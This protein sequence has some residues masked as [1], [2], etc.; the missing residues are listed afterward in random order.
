MIA[1]GIFFMAIF[2]ILAMVSSVLRNAR[3]L[4]GWMWTPAWSPLRSIRRT[5]CMKASSPA[6]SATPP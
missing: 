5:S 3:A 1:C 4:R 2:A 6:T